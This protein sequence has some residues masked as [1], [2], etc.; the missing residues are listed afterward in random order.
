MTNDDKKDLVLAQ[1]ADLNLYNPF[2]K[3]K[4]YVYQ[5][6]ITDENKQIDFQKKLMSMSVN[7]LLKQEEALCALAIKVPQEII[8]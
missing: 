3:D 8:G 2:S 4:N 6:P 1:L 7:S 5:F